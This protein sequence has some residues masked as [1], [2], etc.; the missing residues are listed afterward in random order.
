MSFVDY[1]V[2]IRSAEQRCPVSALGTPAQTVGSGFVPCFRFS[3]RPSGA[4]PLVLRRSAVATTNRSTKPTGPGSRGAQGGKADDSQT[5]TV[6]V[7]WITAQVQWPEVRVP[8]RQEISDS[9]DRVRE[10][11]PS[12]GQLAYFGGLAGL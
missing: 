10:N 7:P 12:A 9:I 6:R 11:L 1:F 5:P 4:F 3:P 2:V 8:D